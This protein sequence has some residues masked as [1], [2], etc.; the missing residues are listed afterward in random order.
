M[1]CTSSHS[2][3]VVCKDSQQ[4]YTNH[5]IIPSSWHLLQDLVCSRSSVNGY[6]VNESVCD[7]CWQ[8]CALPRQWSHKFRK[9]REM[10]RCVLLLGLVQGLALIPPSQEQFMF[11]GMNCTYSSQICRTC[12]NEH[13]G[14]WTTMTTQ[15]H[16]W[17]YMQLLQKASLNRVAYFPAMEWEMR[18]KNIF[19]PDEGV[20]S[21]FSAQGV[22]SLLCLNSLVFPI[23]EA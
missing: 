10:Q 2:W 9:E 16:V 8:S 15:C 1:A 19:L 23:V 3:Y 4:L 18:N 6:R 12:G 14:R 17:V 11:L 22:V 7:E 21:D 20:P 13:V 5:S